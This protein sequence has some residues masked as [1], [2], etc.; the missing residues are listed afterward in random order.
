M[1]RQTFRFNAGDIVCKMNGNSDEVLAVVLQYVGG[2]TNLPKYT[3]RRP[4]VSDH[5]FF[6]DELEPEWEGRTPGIYDK[7]P[8]DVERWR[9]RNR[10]R[11]ASGMSAQ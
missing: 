10:R 1:A 4:D 6:D 2:L 8:D 3:C 5:D 7:C 11:S 9:N